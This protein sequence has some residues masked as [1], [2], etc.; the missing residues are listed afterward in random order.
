[1]LLAQKSV[2]F[3]A[4]FSVHA[5][6]LFLPEKWAAANRRSVQGTAARIHFL[7]LR[8]YLAYNHEKQTNVAKLLKAKAGTYN[9]AKTI[10]G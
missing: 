9:S 3:R 4:A 5:W 6:K 1:M 8:G 2:A 7:Q 10:D